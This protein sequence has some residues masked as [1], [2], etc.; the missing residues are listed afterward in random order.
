MSLKIFPPTY[1]SEDKDFP[2][3]WQK[4]IR[5]CMKSGYEIDT[6]YGNKSKDINSLIVLSGKAIHQIKTRKIHPKFPTKGA[7][8]NQYVLQFTPEFD[9]D[10]FE[11][12]Y[13]DRLTKY[14]ISDGLVKY[15]LNQL[16]YLKDS[17]RNSRRLQAITWVPELDV[18]TDEPPCLQRIWIRVLE[19]PDMENYIYG[20]GQVEVHFTWRSR[21]LYGAWMSNLVGLVMMVYNEILGDDYEIVKIVDFV[22]AA[23]IYDSDF[24]LAKM[25]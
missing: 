9:A 5:F 17:L 22:N 1:V 16:Q 21:D 25:V 2:L 13:Y 24:Q 18:E 8:L 3:S 6:E 14:P 12:T 23:H 7:H 19:E 15:D 4:V 11:Y 20:K 10:V